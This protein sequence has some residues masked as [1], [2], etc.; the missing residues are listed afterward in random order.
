MARRSFSLMLAWRYLNPRRAMLSA[1]TIISVTGVLLG[2][3]IL[4]TVMSVFNGLE[5]EVKN[6]LLGYTP[7]IKL[8]FAP[9]GYKQPLGDWREVAAEINKHPG[10][11][12]V[13][14]FVQDF[15]LLAA[16]GRRKPY[17]FR[18]IDTTD[19]SQVAGIEQLLDKKEH[20]DSSADMGL[21]KE[22][23]ISSIVAGDLGVTVG[24][25]IKF[26]STSNLEQVE[27]PYDVVGQPPA[28]ERYK[29][30]IAA[31]KEVLSAHL[32]KRGDQVLIPEAAYD[33]LIAFSDSIT[34]DFESLRDEDQEILGEFLTSLDPTDKIAEGKLLPE[35]APKAA[36][37]LIAR[38]ESA[39]VDKMDLKALKGIKALILPQEAT[40]K[41]IFEPG[42]MS[43][44][45]EIFMPL[46]LAQ[47]L[48]GLTD[49]IQALAIR[50]DN[51]YEA[52]RIATDLENKLPPGWI[53]TTWYA[54]FGDFAKLIGQQRV[55][56]YIV[57]SMIIVISAFS[58]MAVMFTVT[59]QK[60]REIGVMK[61]LGAAPGQIVCVFLYQGVILGIVGSLLGVGLGLLTLRSLGFI[62]HSMRDYF[63]FDPFTKGFNG[64]DVLP[65]VIVPK[66]VVMIALSA[67][68]LCSLAAMV[69]AF[70]ASR[71]DAAKSLRNL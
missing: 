65:M 4:V 70:F 5:S 3:W 36:L 25:K 54:E 40:V 55:M 26:Y 59:I 71:S 2:V 47:Q 13:T 17:V 12:S 22:V 27:R 7:H 28:R 20:P 35:A 16:N 23:V 18:A 46:P 37:D 50:L 62:Q 38:L 48:S 43:V 30:H 31:A 29:D 6:R 39:D 32:E 58:M 15:A 66:E 60:R 57:L 64:F 67:F 34:A 33:R 53:S 52:E 11:K 10:V 51:S 1:V 8:E 56:M 44:M 9:D 63:G 21:E 68:I 69:P 41:G 61:A 42:H 45:P 24:D 49:S 14:P 19:P